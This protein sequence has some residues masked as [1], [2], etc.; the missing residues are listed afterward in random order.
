MIDYDLRDVALSHNGWIVNGRWTHLC[1]VPHAVNCRCGAIAIDCYD[2]YV[3]GEQQKVMADKLGIS[4]A[5]VYQ[6]VSRVRLCKSRA[7]KQSLN[8]FHGIS[9]KDA[10]YLVSCLN[11]IIDAAR[12]PVPQQES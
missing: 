8:A 6:H 3:G 4:A 9:E 2:R 1:G 7:I 10:R 12:V 5:R 11:G